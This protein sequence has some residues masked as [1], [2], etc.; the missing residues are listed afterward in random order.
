MKA[1]QGTSFHTCCTSQG[2]AGPAGQPGMHMAVHVACAQAQT[3]PKLDKRLCMGG[4][5]DKVPCMTTLQGM[6]LPP[7]CT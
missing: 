6:T 5:D 7:P 1:H 3:N 2:L 4:G